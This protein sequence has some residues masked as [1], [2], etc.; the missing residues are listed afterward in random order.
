MILLIGIVLSSLAQA[1]SARSPGQKAEDQSSYIL[2]RE[3]DRTRS[4]VLADHRESEAP[5]TEIDWHKQAVS[6]SLGQVSDQSEMSET[7]QRKFKRG[8]MAYFFGQYQEARVQWLPLAKM[9]FADAQANLGWL[10][11]A[12]LGV[13]RDYKIAREWYEKADKQSHPVAQNNLGTLYEKGWGVDKDERKAFGYFES[14]A[15]AGYRYGQYNLGVAY[16]EGK[17]I[18]KSSTEAL[19]W[20]RRARE[21]GVDE[22][23][24]RINQ[25][26][27]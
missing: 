17:G 13:E 10:Y 1:E 3:A 9:G 6:R 5:Q 15:K 7:M 20:L 11:Q 23:G 26:A 18:A 24:A 25:L 21:S 4:Q 2:D 22:A 19:L 8:Q 16:Q 27:H 14:A 12:G